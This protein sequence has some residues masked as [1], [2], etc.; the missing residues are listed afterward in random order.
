M[1]R[2]AAWLAVVAA[3][4][5]AVWLTVAWSGGDG[6]LWGW[7]ASRG[8][9]KV[10][11]RG[12]VWLPRWRFLRVAAGSLDGTVAASSLEGA[13]INV[14]LTVVP[15]VGRWQLAPAPTPQEG[16]A[17]AARQGVDGVLRSV[18]L[19]CLA[20]SAPHPGTTCP[21]DLAGA[22]ARAAA[23]ALG[24][25][26][27]AV[28]V[29]LEPDPEAMRRYLL[30]AIR[31]ALPATSR[32]V[33]VIGLDATD[34]QL[35]MPFVDRGLMPNLKKLLSI[36]AWGEMDTIVPMLSPLIW[37]TMATG[38]GP[39]Q[40]GILDFVE[41]DPKTGNM[42]PITGRDRRVP[43]IWNI[44]SALG[45]T[46]DVVGWWATWPAEKIDG[47]M[48]SDRLYFTL[49]QGISKEVLRGDPPEMVSP[50]DQTATFTELRD[51]AVKE[52]DWKT[53]R[54]FMD[55]PEAAY[56]AAVKG[57]R[58]WED[59]IDGTRRIV[60]STRTYFGS[61]LLLAEHQP[62][63]LM[64]YI[65]GT[66]EIGHVLAPYMPPPL[67]A[68][69]PATA[70]VYAAAV[71]RYFE[72]VDRWIGRLVEACPLS[73]TTVLVLSDHGFKWGP[74]RPTDLSGTSGP[75]APLWH[76]DH[77][78]FLLAGAG[79]PHLGEIPHRASVYDITPT[80]ATLLG[81]PPDPAWKGRPLPGAGSNTLAP[82]GYGP[83]IPPESYRTGAGTA[84]PVDQ[85]YIAKLHS[86][87]YLSGPSPTDGA[88]AASAPGAQTAGP[89]ASTATRGELNNL[90]I[91]AI[92]D[93]R[94][95]EAE[96]LLGQVIA[97]SPSYPAPHYNLRRLYIE[98]KRFDDAD[99]ELWTAIDLGLRDPERTIDRA[100]ADYEGLGME[101]RAGALLV[102]AT[103]RFPAY[104]PFWVHRLVVELRL[105]QCSE[106][107]RLG[108]EAASRF[109]DSWEV[110][111]F[112]GLTA[113]CAGDRTTAEREL[114]RSLAINPD[115]PKV[116]EALRSLTEQER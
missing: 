77:A 97:M 48:I 5:G 92:N 24:L 55:V 85:E 21:P 83:L 60:A 69:D 45:K 95:D 67:L 10:A 47:T 17:R 94:Y 27:E 15:P 81:L 35:L 101:A 100:A 7:S 115:Q 30:S 8:E 78:M 58:G 37:T 106:G 98:T 93:K 110:H 38:V 80:L 96:K 113:A 20:T 3:L 102:R 76:D 6:S 40:H 26:G 42:L 105:N 39:E 109:P 13:A 33:L 44:T 14:R 74:D 114:R 1:R 57:D 49:T 36:G 70:A 54:A 4:V 18:P 52:T 32:K 79:V 107:V 72:V 29:R 73:R 116:R 62:D 22:V 111:T 25:P 31:T 68:V 89:N 86:L 28:S 66:D 53:M 99:R 112:F 104:E 56:L 41:R 2:I 16:L 9:L 91:L 12:M 34:W 11:S 64:V 61:A 65:E 84:A 51:R 50:P 90:A 59:P 46:T 88:G 23:T 71:P 75:T 63:L 82:V 19:A 108:R 103:E 87:G 43:A